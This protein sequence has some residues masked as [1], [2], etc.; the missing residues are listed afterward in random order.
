MKS[1]RSIPD[2]ILLFDPSDIVVKA[3]YNLFRHLGFQQPLTAAT[4]DQARGVMESNHDLTL[5]IFGQQKTPEDDQKLFVQSQM[6]CP[7]AIGIYLYSTGGDESLIQQTSNEF[8]VWMMNQG[9]IFKAVPKPWDNSQLAQLVMEMLKERYLQNQQQRRQQQDRQKL[10]AQKEMITQLQAER[11]LLQE[12]RDS[13]EAS[14][15]QAETRSNQSLTDTILF[16]L[17]LANL[18]LMRHSRRVGFWCQKVAE[19]LKRPQDYPPELLNIVGTLHDVGKIDL[20]PETFGLPIN[21]LSLA[22]QEAYDAHPTRTI[23]LLRRLPD[24]IRQKIRRPIREHHEKMDG[25]GPLKRFRQQIDPWAR[26]ISIVNHYDHL[27]HTTKFGSPT[28]KE[29]AMEKL[30]AEAY[31]HAKREG[32]YDPALLNVFL[33]LLQESN[34]LEEKELEPIQVTVEQLR[35]GD[36]LAEDLH[37]TTDLLV[38]TRGTTISTESRVKLSQYLDEGQEIDQVWIENDYH[39]LFKS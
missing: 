37:T 27:R 7:D 18:D 26:L 11:Q 10:R 21:Q 28:G 9:S 12:S 38:L 20:P 14:L 24:Q 22:Q 35:A 25:S 32:Q 2:K 8:L 1:R 6:L 23:W 17:Q 33:E 13:L 36:Q 30:E 4:V 31:S 16:M 34:E 15:R 19:E 5:Y 29:H 39:D 3:L